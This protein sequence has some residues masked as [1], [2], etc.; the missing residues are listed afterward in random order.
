MNVINSTEFE[1]GSSSSDST[2]LSIT[3]S[4]HPCPSYRIVTDDVVQNSLPTITQTLTTELHL[5]CHHLRDKGVGHLRVCHQVN[6]L[7]SPAFEIRIILLTDK[8]STKSHK[9][10]LP[11]K[12]LPK[13]FI[14]CTYSSEEFL[15]KIVELNLGF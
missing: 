2:P 8:L 15:C 11:G 13:I 4:A 9:I 5:L 10:C 7:I 1:L 14:Y 6:Y 3:P 12:K